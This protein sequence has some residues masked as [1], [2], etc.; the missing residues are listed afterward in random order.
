MKVLWVKK[1]FM[2]GLNQ[3]KIGKQPHAFASVLAVFS[4][5]IQ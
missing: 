3:Q 4:D 1:R 5:S 2:D